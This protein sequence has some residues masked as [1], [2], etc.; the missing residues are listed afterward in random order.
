MCRR[1]MQESGF[2]HSAFTFSH[3]CMIG[4]TGMRAADKTLPPGA[5]L[6]FLQK[7]LQYVGVEESLRQQQDSQ[8]KVGSNK[9]TNPNTVASSNSISPL[10][11][12]S[13]SNGDFSLLSPVIVSS[14]TRKNP[15]IQLTVP[16]AAAAAAVRARLAHEA[17]IKQKLL[18]QQY[19]VDQ[20]GLLQ[21]ISTRQPVYNFSEAI[22]TPDEVTV[23]MLEPVNNMNPLESSYSF[24][25]SNSIAP[26]KEEYQSEKQQQKALGKRDKTMQKSKVFNGDGKHTQL[27]S[28]SRTTL[29]DGPE[30][31]SSAFETAEK[32]VSNKRFAS[33]TKRSIKKQKTANNGEPSIGSIKAD[34]TSSSVA[35]PGVSSDLS[36]NVA[37]ELNLNQNKRELKSA[38]EV[39][40]ELV[41]SIAE[42]DYVTTP[43]SIGPANSYHQSGPLPEKLESNI[44]RSVKVKQGNKEEISDL[45]PFKGSKSTDD[46][47]SDFI[48]TNE[49]RLL[50]KEEAK[51]IGA[52]NLIESKST[53]EQES[54]VVRS[55][56][57]GH[58]SKE[59]AL[60]FDAIAPSDSMNELYTANDDEILIL[61][62]HSSEVFMCAWNPIFTNL[63][64]TGSGDASARIWEM[65]G[66]YASAGLKKS[67]LLLHSIDSGDTRNKDVT[68]L[69]WS[70]DGTL[71]ATGSYNGIARVWDR[72][73]NLDLLDST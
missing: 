8:T 30:V 60:D 25:P 20:S 73:G 29:S 14:I 1:Y 5:L 48:R 2:V 35:L 44:V 71:L 10:D 23:S 26:L 32:S 41:G 15:P 42:N 64:A 28:T 50:G 57:V 63:I 22:R 58:L 45:D 61:N 40:N 11:G 17:S 53:D 68:T 19:L 49:M 62:S 43:A 13:A 38:L 3:E 70:S 65:S 51:D 24:P 34:I 18:Q 33:D 54:H 72:K 39:Q 55:G 9:K 36:S 37:N 52:N 4:R 47:A 7:G 27:K 69:E 66:K 31:D 12:S 67:I 21:S 6:S 56:K 46:K 59:E 16:P